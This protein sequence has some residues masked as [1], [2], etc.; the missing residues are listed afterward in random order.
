MGF[1]STPSGW[2]ATTGNVTGTHTHWIS[3]HALRVEG[4]RELYAVTLEHKKFL[5]TP[6]GWRATQDGSGMVA[7]IVFL[8]TPSGWRATTLSE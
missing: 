4:D 5:S 3:I 1:L 8:S 7:Q 2:R 6:S